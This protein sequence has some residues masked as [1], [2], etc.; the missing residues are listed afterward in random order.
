MKI[1]QKCYTPKLPGMWI[2]EL[3]ISA[4]VV[5]EY[6]CSYLLNQRG[7]VLPVLFFFRTRVTKCIRHVIE[8]QIEFTEA[9]A[10]VG[11]RSERSRSIVVVF[12]RR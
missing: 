3:Y 1:F 7:E 4:A 11:I 9:F 2:D 6:A 10:Q 8:S 12:C 5:R